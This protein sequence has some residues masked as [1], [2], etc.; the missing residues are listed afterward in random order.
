M[1]PSEL[2]LLRMNTHFYHPNYKLR[3]KNW[4]NWDEQNISP[5]E[6]IDYNN[7]LSKLLFSQL[8]SELIE[9]IILNRHKSTK[10]T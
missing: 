8:P 10:I 6:P 4:A 9:N 5:P 3:I 1:L 7:K 2:I